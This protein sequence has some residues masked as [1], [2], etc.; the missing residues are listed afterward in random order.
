MEIRRVQEKD[1][2]FFD[3]NKLNKVK[4]EQNRWFC[5]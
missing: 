2:R 3:L 4:S 5:I 1:I